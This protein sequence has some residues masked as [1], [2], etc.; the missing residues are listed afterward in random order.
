MPGRAER[1]NVDQMSYRFRLYPTVEQ[2]IQM[3]EFCRSARKV[4]NTGVQQ[5]EFAATHHR[6]KRMNWP[7]HV[8]RDRQLTEARAALDWLAAV[9]R[10]VQSQALRDLDQA[11]RN[12]WGNPT[13]FGRPTFRK[14]GRGGGFAITDV[15][16]RQKVKKINRRWGAVNLPNIG[17]VKF[18][19]TRTFARLL[20][21]KSAR[22]TVDRCGRWHVA[23]PLEPVAIERTR[24]GAVVGIDRGVANTLATSEGTFDHA[25]TLSEGERAEALRRQVA[26]ANENYRGA[27][28]VV[29]K[30]A[31]ARTLARLADRRRDWIEQTTT[32]LVREYDLIAVE[33][34]NVR[35]MVRSAKGT[36]EEPG[37]NVRAKAGLNRAILAQCWGAW[38]ARLKQKAALCG[39][40]VI[41]VSARNTSRRCRACGHTASENRDSQAEFRCVACGHEDHADTNAALNILERGLKARTV[42]EPLGAAA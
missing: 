12:W 40:E 11:Y 21:A 5:F 7:S 33:R 15:A 19:L 16:R 24:T 38:L 22:I 26:R 32:A 13:H 37:V 14:Q 6:G 4:W 18:R 9:P 25:P 27:L 20:D 28:D 2:A 17:W 41:E 36:L 3:D 29:H 34:L 10:V 1:A 35:G 30:Q 8:E 39:V 31:Y 42:P 23:F